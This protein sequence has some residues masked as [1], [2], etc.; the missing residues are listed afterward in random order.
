MQC[1]HPSCSVRRCDWPDKRIT[2]LLHRQ[3][4]RGNVNFNLSLHPSIFGAEIG[5]TNIH[6][7]VGRLA[8][9]LGGLCMGPEL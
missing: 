7:G 3:V 8:F 6:S 5:I 4:A 9:G 1:S 2:W